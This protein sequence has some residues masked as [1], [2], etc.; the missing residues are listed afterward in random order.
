M[1]FNIKNENYWGGLGMGEVWCDGVINWGGGA[2]R[3]KQN[4]LWWTAFM[5]CT[6]DSIWVLWDA[7]RVFKYF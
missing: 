4:G 2:I 7:Q 6:V 5:W 3:L 1:H